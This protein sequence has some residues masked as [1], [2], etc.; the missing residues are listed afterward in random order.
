M[1]TVM[2]VD[3]HPAM[4]EGLVSRLER[5]QD[6]HVCG[7]A[8]DVEEGWQ[9]LHACKPDVAL[10][11]VSL[12]R[13][14]GLELIKQ[15]KTKR[16]TTRTLV[17]SMHEESLYAERALRAGALGYINKQQPTDLI[18]DAIRQVLGGDL[19]LTQKMSTHL[20]Q[21]IVQGGESLGNSVSEVLSD[22]ELQ[23]FELIGRGM[24]T[25]DI[26]TQMQLSPKTVETYRSRIKEKLNLANM[27]SL[28][29]AAVQWV[30]ENH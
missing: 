7:Q 10:V 30:M 17:C 4:R 18:V 28:T 3:D 13:G 15:I 12:K 19:F 8:G 16:L 14:N 11:D 20:L 27:P 25:S 29:Q 1:T 21:R 2:I 24:N 23:T 5:E 22:R 6:F 26:A 9:V